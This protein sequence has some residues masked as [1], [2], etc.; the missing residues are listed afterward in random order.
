M[1]GIKGYDHKRKVMAFTCPVCDHEHEYDG[2]AARLAKTHPTERAAWGL[3]LG[4]CPGCGSSHHLNC[5]LPDDHPHAEHVNALLR[6]HHDAELPVAS[7]KPMVN[8]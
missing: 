1:H 8:R 4:D 7:L 2:S 6:E 5:N 3:H